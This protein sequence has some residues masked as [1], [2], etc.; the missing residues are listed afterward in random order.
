[1]ISRSTHNTQFQLWLITDSLYGS[2]VPFWPIWLKSTERMTHCTRKT[3]RLVQLLINVSISIWEPCINVLVVNKHLILFKV[4]RTNWN[5]WY[6]SD[7]YYPQIFAKAPADP[8][9][10]AK[11]EEALAFLNI[12]L[13]KSKYSAGEKF[14]VADITLLATVSSLEVAG[15]DF[16]KYS[17][18]TRWYDLVKTT[19]PGHEINTAG[20]VEFKKF[21][22]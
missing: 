17:N 12:F 1:M 21:F 19:A 2:L 9:K 6:F 14:T 13:E 18:V 20:L 10:F 5:L 15:F 22:A 4:L 3:L 7:Y 16:S 8:E 11:I